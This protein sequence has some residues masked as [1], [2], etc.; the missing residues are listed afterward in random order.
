M[1]ES[2]TTRPSLLVR[3]RDQR[4]RQAWAE[5]VQIYAPLV[6]AF[7]QKKGLQDADAADLTQEV[8]RAVAR[9]V[10]R[11]EYDPRRGSFRGWLFTIVR[12]ELHD[13]HAR[14]RGRGSGDSDQQWRLEQQPAR[15]D[16]QETWDHEYER[17]LL[18]WAAERIRRDFQETTWQAFWLTAVQGKSGK[19]VAA[20]LGMSTAAIYLAK[21]RVM[22][23][24]KEQIAQLQAE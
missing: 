16:D 17:Q 12:N 21:R 19:E 15:A 18:A 13:W 23:R 3:I 2:A 10:P 1:A 11:L 8:L 4:D 14:Q 7:A 24:L 6:Y 5:F 20:I 9:A 22:M